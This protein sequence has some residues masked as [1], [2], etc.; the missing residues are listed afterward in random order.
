MSEG[1]SG[2]G[3]KSTGVIILIIALYFIVNGVT[4]KEG[5]GI[6][7]ESVLGE[8]L[9]NV[10]LDEQTGNVGAGILGVLLGGGMMGA[11]YR[12]GRRDYDDDD[13]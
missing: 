5:A 6:L 4:L 12:R 13:D 1:K 10:D 8:L 2:K 7:G 9:Q 3:L 11:G